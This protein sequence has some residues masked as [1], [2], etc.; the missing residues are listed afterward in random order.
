MLIASADAEVAV[1]EIDNTLI[2]SGFANKKASRPYPT[3]AFHAHLGF[4]YVVPEFRGRGVNQ[5]VLQHL[6][7][8]ARRRGLLEI[9]LTVYPENASAVRAYEKAGFQSHLIEM[10][11]QLDA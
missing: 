9:R 7:D 8:W 6:L 10:R 4:M 1:A 3:P 11:R 5:L 2:G